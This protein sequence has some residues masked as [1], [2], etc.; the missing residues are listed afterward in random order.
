[1][2]RKFLGYLCLFLLW[3]Y[4]SWAQVKEISDAS[5]PDIAR[6][7]SDSNEPSGAV[8]VY[9][10]DFCDQIGPACEFFRA[11][12]YGHIALG[13]QFTH[14]GNY[15]MEKE[16]DADRYAAAYAHPGVICAAYHLFKNGGSSANFPIYGT[17]PQRA[18]RLR[19]FAM[20][21]GTWNCNP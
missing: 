3:P 16:R 14:P 4:L 2:P 18:Q 21:A 11:H 6:V 9:N 20:Q 17:P 13:H 7:I 8:I 15:A 5:L 1:M 10:P 19:Q 12:E